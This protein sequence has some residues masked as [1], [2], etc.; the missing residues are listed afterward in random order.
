LTQPNLYELWRLRLFSFGGYGLALA[1]LALVAFGAIEC[2]PESLRDIKKHWNVSG[3]DHAG[4]GFR[5]SGGRPYLAGPG[6]PRHTH[7]L[8]LPLGSLAALPN[9]RYFL[10]SLAV[11][12]YG[13]HLCVH[14]VRLQNAQNTGEL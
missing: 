8:P 13:A 5:A 4:P 11:L 12:Q 7:A 14:S 6:A 3:V 9:Q 2:P 1:A 10:L